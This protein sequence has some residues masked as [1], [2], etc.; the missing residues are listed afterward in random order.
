MRDRASARGGAWDGDVLQPQLATWERL[1]AFV[2]D[3]DKPQLLSSALLQGL[4]DDLCPAGGGR[5]QEIGRIVNPH[6][7]LAAVSHR[8]AGG[9]FDGGR[10]DTA[11][12]PVPGVW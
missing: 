5:A 7:E 9:G 10:V 12:H 2:P 11:V 3:G 6:R 1:P 4:G 8:Q